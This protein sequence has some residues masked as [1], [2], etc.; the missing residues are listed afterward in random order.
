[1][2]VEGF[3]LDAQKDRLRREAT[4]RGMSVA[5]EYSDEGKSG[6]NVQGRPEFMRMLEDIKSDKDGISYVLVF[7]LSRFGRN[8]AD[9]LNSLQTMQNYGV[10]L[11]CVEDGI[12]SSK[13]AGKLMIS[14]LAA[15]AEIEKENIREQT[16][17]GRT[18]KAKEGKWNGGFA[19]YGYKLVARDG[20]KHKF[21][22]V[23][24]DEADIIRLI[25]DKYVNTPMGT[26]S[27][28]KWLNEHG[29]KK[30]VRQN[31]SL[32]GFADK[33]IVGVLDNPVYMGKISYGRRK[34]EN[35]K[36]TNGETRIVKQP[37]DSWELY[38][39]LHEP[40]VSED[41]WYKAQAK[42][43]HNGGAREKTHSTWH[44][45]ILSTIVKCPE[46]GA[47][48]Y[49]SVNRKKNI[50]K[51]GEEVYYDSWYYRCNHQV[52]QTGH[53]VCKYKKY[54]PQNEVNEQVLA[55]VKWV[56]Q[57]S[58]FKERVLQTVGKDDSSDELIAEKER[59][60]KEI[61]KLAIKKKKMMSKLMALD[62]DDDLYDEMY[63]TF[64]E[65]VHQ[66]IEEKAKFD[67]KL[68]NVNI[69]ISNAQSEKFSAEH[70]YKVLTALVDEMENLPDKDLKILLQWVLDEVQIHRERQDTGFW[71]KSIRFKIPINVDGELVDTI[72]YD[73]DDEAETDTEVVAEEGS[74]M[75]ESLENTG[76][77]EDSEVEEKFSLKPSTVETVVLLGNQKTKPDSHIKLSVD[78]DEFNKVKNGEK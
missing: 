49:G 39:G 67:S 51:A 20:Y 44:E 55:V 77:S 75:A 17:A 43:K 63:K 41:T 27:V 76:V 5:G 18:Q 70:Y 73:R 65:A 47:S 40:L 53:N 74:E 56:L 26:N 25:F 32:T 2:Q 48:M 6:K 52:R 68:M 31:G 16:M 15:V 71:V 34:H 36:G 23:A 11:I 9:T 38:D 22:E 60:E 72:Y 21:L 4:M 78:M 37:K 58:D 69:A 57:D 59:L 7:K 62:V 46:C 12:D 35:I 61:G 54:V 28:A 33:F 66:I 8:A 10:N 13:D 42:R 3:S 45:H 30:K 50:N 29:Y 24:E 19:P 1:M 64:E 14:V